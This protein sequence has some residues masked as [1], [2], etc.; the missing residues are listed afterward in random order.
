MSFKED[1][2]T[3]L[4]ENPK[5]LS[6]RYFY[7]AEGDKIFQAI[8]KMP[9]YYLTNAE[10]EIFSTQA[11]QI[12]S[13]LD[14]NGRKFDLVE[15]GAGDGFKT[16]IL[17]ERLIEAGANFRYIPIDISENVL[18]TLKSDFQKRFP[19]LEILAENAEYFEALESINRKSENPKVILFLG[20]SIGNFLEDR[21]V[22]FLNALYA[23]LNVGDFTLIGFD[24]KKNPKTI[25]EAYNDKQGITKAFNL[26][27]LKRINRELEADFDLE[28]FDHYPYY[29]P[30]TGFAK[31]YI[32]SLKKQTVNIKGLKKQFVF[33]AGE[34]I[35]TEISRK[36]GINQIETLFE[37]ANFNVSKHFFDCK[38][39]YVDTLAKKI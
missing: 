9:E 12:L 32:V 28:A 27:L 4:S 19:D 24:L 3:G 34:A 30:E 8:M 22:R 31:S 38:H 21:T 20:S 23:V 6:S 18:N 17:I 39:Y 37:N 1:V 15:F 7:D 33:D 16:R 35:H 14:V 25:L 36:Y 13:E 29:D 26:N 5:Y 10:F 11:E 2:G